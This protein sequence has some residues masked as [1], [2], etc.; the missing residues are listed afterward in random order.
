MNT[1]SALARYILLEEPAHLLDGDVGPARDQ[2]GPQLAMLSAELVG[3]LDAMAAGW[4]ARRRPRL[5]ARL[6]RFR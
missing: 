2:A 1:K 3:Q 4:P 5:G 6:I